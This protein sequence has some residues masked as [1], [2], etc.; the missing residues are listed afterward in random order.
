[1]K[2]QVL[3]DNINSWILPYAQELTQKLNE[4]S[5]VE[6]VLI[7]TH[8]QIVKGDVLV[9]LSCEQ[10]LKKLDLNTYNIV[11]HES[12]LPE[13]RGWSPLTWKILEGKNE[14]PVT[15]FEATDKVDAGKVYLR[16]VLVFEGHE[17]VDEMKHLQGLKTNEMVLKFVSKFPLIEGEEQVGTPSYYPR[18]RPEDSELDI[19]K[20]IEEQINLLRVCDNERYPAYFKYK[21]FTYTLKIEKNGK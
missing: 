11:V 15:L 17:L 4:Q 19:S 3:V 14:I 8:E 5:N 21:G 9:L 20:T 2:V 6:A 10:I 7:H 1:M 16:D 18:R 12:E 13:G